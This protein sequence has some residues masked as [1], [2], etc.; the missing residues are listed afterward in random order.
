MA[1]EITTLCKNSKKPLQNKI[2]LA[3]TNKQLLLHSTI[4]SEK[5]ICI[6]CALTA[7]HARMWSE[8]EQGFGPPWARSTQRQAGGS[9]A[10]ALLSLVIFFSP[11][12]L[13]IFPDSTTISGPFYIRYKSIPVFAG[14]HISIF[15]P[16]FPTCPCCYGH[17]LWFTHRLGFCVVFLMI[18]IYISLLNCAYVDWVV[19]LLT[20]TKFSASAKPVG[21]NWSVYIVE[22]WLYCWLTC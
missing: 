5:P 21:K 13:S 11:I 3:L 6:S 4:K 15:F 2:N 17:T 7:M 22:L 20:L 8:S 14:V 1:S 10:F 9:V 19:V 18:I 16:L 12:L